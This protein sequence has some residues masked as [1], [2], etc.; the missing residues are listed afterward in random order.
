VEEVA[1]RVN[2]A[3]T[4]LQYASPAIASLGLVLACLSLWLQR[5]D[6]R[7]RLRIQHKT[8]MLTSGPHVSDAWAQF[9]VA[10]SGEQTITVTSVHLLLR[11]GRRIPIVGIRD[12]MIDTDGS[13]SFVSLPRKL[14]AGESVSLLTELHPLAKQ[15]RS[16]SYCPKAK[17]KI[18]VTDAADKK[19]TK[20][21]MINTRE[22]GY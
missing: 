18:E 2:D 7:P 11:D 6:K 14:T 21:S 5:L 22:W 12:R 3:P 10:N 13:P 4:W 9:H 17:F 20:R 1:R 19:Y 16:M 8:A 15:L